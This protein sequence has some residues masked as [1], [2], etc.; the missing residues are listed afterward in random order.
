MEI[1]W[2]RDLILRFLNE[3]LSSIGDL[4]TASLPPREGKAEVIAKED[5]I[6]CGIPFFEMVFKLYDPSVT[7]SWRK[8]EG[9]EVKKG[10]IIGKVSGNL[11]TI[12]ICERTALNLLQRL[13][14]IATE[15]RKYAERLR[16]TGIT[17][18]DTRKTTP[19][20]RA[21]EKYATR[22]GGARNHRFGLFDAAMVK[23]NHIRAYGGVAEAVKA[24]YNT[25][26]ATASIEVEVENWDQLEKLLQVIEMVDIVM[27]DNWKFEEVNAA[28]ELLKS[29][30]P[31]IKIELSGGI[32]LES[33]EKVKGLKV[34]FISTSKIITGA[35]W[36]DVSMEVV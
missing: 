12:L 22:I 11:K 1:P 25:I 7:F 15:T 2:I 17:L 33:L 8:E 5:F 3:D 30:K 19:G 16:E 31:G 34:D 13:S 36:V 24:V 10:E 32:T 14:G 27:L 29:R 6:L 28:V 26:P 4:S 21:L 35:T 9:E 23:D 20:L 18:L